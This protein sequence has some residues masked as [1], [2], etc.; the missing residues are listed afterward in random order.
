MSLITP[1]APRRFYHRWLYCLV[2]V[3]LGCLI[4]DEALG[5][6]RMR[7]GTLVPKGS[8]YYNHLKTMESAWKRSPGGGV[9]ISIYPD[10]RLGGEAEMVRR[11]RGRQ[12]QVGLL[13]VAGL[14]E[15]EPRVIVSLMGMAC[16]DEKYDCLCR[17]QDMPMAEPE[18]VE[19]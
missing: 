4:S 16:M 17:A 5:A 14:A 3:I 12:L 13:T 9:S 18:E 6:Q 2:P 11:M 10:G 1:E 15:I 7:L 8:S 19:A